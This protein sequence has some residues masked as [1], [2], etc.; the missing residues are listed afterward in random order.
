MGRSIER[1]RDEWDSSDDEFQRA[2]KDARAAAKVFT[3]AVA[4]TLTTPPRS[5][6]ARRLRRPRSRASS[7]P[8]Q[9]R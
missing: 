3:T 4:T 8:A 9:S 6:W 1:V 5:R 2:Y 7:L